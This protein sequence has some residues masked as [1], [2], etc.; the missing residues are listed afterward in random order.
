LCVCTCIYKALTRAIFVTAIAIAIS[1]RTTAAC[2]HGVASEAVDQ[3]EYVDAADITRDQECGLG[4][5]M[6]PLT[7]S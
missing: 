4:H 6:G 1:S 5:M 3:Q 2:Q 7:V